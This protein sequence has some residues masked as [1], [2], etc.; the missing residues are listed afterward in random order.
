MLGRY[1]NAV[2]VKS[3]DFTLPF[4]K[5]AELLNSA[6]ITIINFE[7]TLIQNCPIVPDKTLTFCGDP[8]HVKGLQFAGVDIANLANNHSYN[9]GKD[10]LNQTTDLLEGA[11]IKVSGLKK[12]AFIEVNN[13]K[14]AF[15]GFNQVPPYPAEI[16]HAATEEI[17]SEVSTA[18]TN[19][20]LVVV[21][22]HW[23]NEYTAVI[24]DIQKSLA[25]TAID[26]GADLVIGHHPHWIQGT[27]IYK[28]KLIH[29]SLGNFIFDQDWS[30][31]TQLGEVVK[32]TFDK[33]VMTNYEIIP[34]KIEENFQP[35]IAN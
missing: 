9:Y 1:V 2:T 24:T 15:I 16:G 27:E 33:N 21:S 7:G 4:Q 5:T 12:P 18:K 8:R 17:I 23:G 34:I 25:H 14:I 26:S 10:G 31:K 20:D 30:E 32:V 29:Y 13:T 19:A 3:G 6:D 35:R 22:F 28:E 11:G